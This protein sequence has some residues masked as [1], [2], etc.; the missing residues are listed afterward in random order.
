MM[1][2]HLLKVISFTR[3]ETLT[4]S[5]LLTMVELFFLKETIMVL[6]QSTLN[7]FFQIINLGPLL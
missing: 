5:F 4:L 3:K 1:T 6:E 2:T 7:N